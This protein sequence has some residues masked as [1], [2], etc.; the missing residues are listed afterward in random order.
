MTRQQE[1]IAMLQAQK[2]TLREI[3]DEFL[4]TQEEIALDLR[5]IQNAIRPKMSLEQTKPVCNT[6]GFVYKDRKDKNK[7]R[8]PTKCPKCHGED[9]EG[10]RYL[11]EIH[12]ANIP[13]E[14][15]I[16]VPTEDGADSFG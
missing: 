16:D 2:M 11:I 4:A 8:P 10:P 7:V 6:C 13:K 9:I 3:S 15:R 12:L 5:E 1:I 14:E